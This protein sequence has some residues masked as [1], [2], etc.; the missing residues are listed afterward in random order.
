MTL[1]TYIMAK[2]TEKLQIRVRTLI[3]LFMTANSWSILIIHIYTV[4]NS[5]P[6]LSYK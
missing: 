3:I 2:D 5:K 6:V 4:A 1:F